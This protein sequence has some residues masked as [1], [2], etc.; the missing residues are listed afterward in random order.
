MNY[1][2]IEN[3]MV[4]YDSD[5]DY[6]NYEEADRITFEDLSTS[7]KTAVLEE[8]E[9]DISNQME[10]DEYFALTPEALEEI[11]HHA[12]ENDYD[13][14][15]DSDGVVHKERVSYTGGY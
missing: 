13:Y 6:Y 4:S 3:H 14:W 11:I 5:W 1:L 15:Y 2:Q 10:D 9:V 12:A 8:I 7:E